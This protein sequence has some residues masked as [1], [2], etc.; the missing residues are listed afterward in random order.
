MMHVLDLAM[1][2]LLRV[3]HYACMLSNDALCAEISL[4]L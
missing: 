3:R 1:G 2:S 4:R